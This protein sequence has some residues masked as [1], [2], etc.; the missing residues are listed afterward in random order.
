MTASAILLAILALG[1]GALIGYL[2]G[3]SRSR[4]GYDARL[5]EA[6]N[7]RAA[8][9]ATTTELRGQL[10]SL[11]G[12]FQE[13][14]KR[15]ESE[16][17]QRVATETA[18][19]AA[20]KSLAEQRQ[21]LEQ[22]KDEM[23]S[24]FRALA[25]EALSATTQQ[26]L[27]LAKTHL[28]SELEPRQ[29]AIAGM[30]NPLSDVLKALQT[31]LQQVESARQQAYGELRSQVQQL[32]SVGR[33]LQDRTGT[34][35]SALQQPRVRGSWGE[36]TLRRAVELAGMSA[37][38]DFA[39]QQTIGSETTRL[40]PDLTVHLPG[41]RDIAVDAKV[42]LK[43]FTEASEAKN[44]AERQ[45]AI[46]RH[47]QLVRAHIQQLGSKSYWSEM[48]STPEFVVLFMPGESFF[49]AALESDRTL[50]EDAQSHGVI[51]ASPTTLIALLKAAAYGWQQKSMEENTRRIAQLGQVL[52]ERIEKFVE[53]LGE[54][55]KGLDRAS[56]SYNDAVGSFNDRLLPS[57]RRLGELGVSGEPE[58]AAIEPT[59]VELRQ[60]PREDGANPPEE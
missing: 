18:L 26:F 53:H 59:D 41:G 30:V 12:Q 31:Q 45:E 15:L 60:P 35:A 48:P 47:V 4:T 9:D 2:Y 8:L 6:E 42:P 39:E 50:I 55:R 25:S 1:V 57:V 58:M 17:A 7:G 23:K 22:T 24:V 11:R 32:A 49:S 56:R 14:Q 51:L 27:D 10:E 37:H 3:S 40:R 19:D 36:L 43:A 54:I 28:E 20:D 44:E 13:Q 33:E 21:A 29:V 5:R 52:Y 46:R 34:L 38:C 16:S